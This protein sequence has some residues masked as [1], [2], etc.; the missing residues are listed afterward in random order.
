MKTTL[1]YLFFIIII[2]SCGSS[3]DNE[4]EV[5]PD[6][7]DGDGVSNITETYIGTDPENSCSFFISSLLTETLEPSNSWNNTD[8]DGDGMNNEQEILNGTHPLF[9]ENIL[10]DNDK[11]KSIYEA[12]FFD[13]TQKKWEITF[14]DNGNKL[15]K[16]FN[17]G[18]LSSHFQ[19]DTN[20]KLVFVETTAFNNTNYEVT[21]EYDT[22]N[23]ISSII[24]ITTDNN[25]VSNTVTKNYVYENNIIQ[26]YN[27]TGYNIE[28]YTL[29]AFNKIE[30][31]KKYNPYFEASYHMK[32]EF[33]FMYSDATNNLERIQSDLYE[34][35]ND[36]YSYYD[37]GPRPVRKY[38]YNEEIPNNV[39][40]AFSPIYFNFILVPEI[41][42]S[43]KYALGIHCYGLFESNFLI[44]N[45]YAVEYSS[46]GSALISELD[47]IYYSNNLPYTTEIE[48][49][50]GNY[51]TLSQVFYE[52]E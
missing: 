36:S 45:S 22:S 21:Y 30:S 7:L 43:M 40:N 31:I 5:N 26:V 39:L 51:S 47:Y 33:T 34:Y 42:S 16:I 13:D 49:Y 12:I 1:K 11:I 27:E 24:T 6:D 48:N 19:Y 4:E 20:N 8:C 38:I 37:T 23:R 18:V 46:A 28:T 10:D 2:F 25:G 41:F 44:R 9:P 32:E 14:T 29:N 52:Y 50:N 15:D 17:L 35:V 3:N